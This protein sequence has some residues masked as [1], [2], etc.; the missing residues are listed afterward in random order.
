[1]QDALSDYVPAGKTLIV[2]CTAPIRRSSKTAAEFAEMVAR[3]FEQK[4]ARLDFK[5]TINENRVRARLVKAAP[6]H[7]ARVVGFV[8]NP[9]VDVEALMSS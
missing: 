9:D 1:L 2:T 7:D 5:K 8:H 4:P 6:A 3:A